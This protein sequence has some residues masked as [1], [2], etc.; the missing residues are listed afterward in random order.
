VE[1]LDP[2][3]VTRIARRKNRPV[4]DGPSCNS[5]I[6]LRSAGERS[7]ATELRNDAGVADGCLDLSSRVGRSY[8]VLTGR[9]Q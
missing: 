9:C 2:V 1:G 3:E 4:L 5:E 7:L 8:E 6:G